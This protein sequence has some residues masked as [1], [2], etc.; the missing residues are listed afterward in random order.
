M[1]LQPGAR[2]GR[3]PRRCGVHGA[4]RA[5]RRTAGPP[6][7]AGRHRHRGAA[8]APADP[9]ARRGGLPHERDRLRAHRAAGP[10]RGGGRRSGR[11]RAGA[12]VP[13]ARRGGHAPE[14]RH[15]APA[16]RGPGRGRD[17]PAGASPGR[18]APDPRRPRWPAS[19]REATRKVVRYREGDARERRRGRRDP[20]RDRPRAERRGARARGGRGAPHAPRASSW[21]TTFEPRTRRVYAAGDVCLGWKFTHAADAAARIVVQNALFGLAGRRRGEPARHAVVHVHGPGGG[22]RRAQRARGARARASAIDTLVRRLEDVDRAR[23]D[24]ET[25]GFVKVH[26]RRGTDRIVGATIVARRAG[27]LIS[28]V[29]LAIVAGVGLGRLSDVI[30]PYPTQAEAV[31]HLADQYRRTRLTPSCARRSGPGSGGR[32]EPRAPS[33][34]GPAGRSSRSALLVAGLLAWALGLYDWVRPERLARLRT[35]IEAYGGWAPALYVGGY[36]V[37][38]APLRPRASP[39]SPRRPRVRAGMGHRVHVDRGDP[40]GRPRFPGRPAPGAGHRGAM[41]RRRAPGSR[42]STRPSS[43]TAGAS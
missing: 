15:A 41:D 39:D 25:E 42:G 40:R 14:R 38:G 7:R 12:G 28:E 31:R 13:A 10:P 22:A 43:V 2:R 17:R 1:A 18:R 33:G 11:L 16:P 29:T 23:T 9:G 32:G 19:G 4:G 36:V 27:E 5:E 35:A 6:L 24:G 21:T 8:R 26:V 37:G 30:H 3:L 34:A 20:R